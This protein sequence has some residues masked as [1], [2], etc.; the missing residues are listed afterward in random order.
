MHRTHRPEEVI[1]ALRML[2]VD[3][4]EEARSGHP[5]MP[6][7]AAPMAYVLFF[8]VMQHNP[9]NPQW[10]NRDR[11]ILSAGHGSALLYALLYLSGYDLSIEDLRRFRQ[12]GSRTPGHPEYGLTPGVETTTGPLGQGFA[13]GVGMA[14]AERI[15]AQRF[16]REDFPLVDHRVYAI[17]SDGDLMEGISH[18]AASLAGHWGLGRLIYLYD[19]NGITIDGTTD[20]AF[21]EDVRKRFEAYGWQVLEV[22]DG[23]DLEA[24]RQA[25]REA[26][27]D[28][29]HP[30]LIRVRTHIGYGSPLQDTSRVHGAPL[31][32]EAWEKTREFYGWPKERFWIPEGMEALREAMRHRGA[33]MEN[34]WRDLARRYAERYPEQWATFQRWLDRELPAEIERYLPRFAAGETI[35]TRAASGKVINALASAVPNMIGGSADL[36]DSNKTR[37]VESSPIRRGDFRGRN[38]HFGVRE[39]AMGGILNGM[40][41]Y[42]GLFPFGGTFLVFSDYMR[43]AIRIAA[44]AHLHVIYVFTHDSVWLGEDG[45]THQPVEHLASLRAMPNLVVIRPADAS[46]TAWAWVWALRHRGGPVALVLSRQ[47]IP[48]IDRNRYADARLAM[49]GAYVLARSPESDSPRLVLVGTGSEVALILQAY[50]ILR[51]EFP[52]QV[53]SFP[54]WE[55]FATQD[56]EYR[57]AVL[58][59]GVP[60]LVVEAGSSLGW[61]R[62][63]DRGKI[64]SL[65]RFG[66][67]G[68]YPDLMRHF[69]FTVERVVEE[70]RA[71]LRENA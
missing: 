60:K 24:L 21:S 47:S 45:P 55:I 65:D 41:Y 10:P 46:E 9:T 15:F 42:G 49:R 25:L 13:N 11:F 5:G 52:L 63:V 17:V 56:P 19:D 28:P 64:L 7:G 16:N 69:G 58:P 3:M 59:P 51:E 8:E 2:A 43:P 33:S 6:L 67:S 1:T 62:W 39:H 32:P 54:S 30:S 44:L 12:L 50:E 20:L 27:D 14:L 29:E 23:N 36:T 18:E 38:I 37:I 22:D 71:L 40:A 53:V 31:G 26:Q 35:A 66:L 34:A 68:P 48:V 70:A 57:E 4:I 61:E